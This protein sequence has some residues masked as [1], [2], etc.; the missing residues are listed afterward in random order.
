MGG[1]P[2]RLAMTRTNVLHRVRIRSCARRHPS[3]GGVVDASTL[4]VRRRPND[5][6]RMGRR[7]DKAIASSWHTGS[8]RVSSTGSVANGSTATHL[9]PERT[10]R[11]PPT[12]RTVGDASR[13]RASTVEE[14]HDGL[15]RVVIDVL[16]VVG[17]VGIGCARFGDALVAPAILECPKKKP[18]DMR[19]AHP[20][21]A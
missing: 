5:L 11:H 15:V 16:S 13:S 3:A 18:L 20:S 14:R 12:Q 19:I 17:S 9:A 7:S 4:C 1:I 8:V 6:I 2:H 21:G 10:R